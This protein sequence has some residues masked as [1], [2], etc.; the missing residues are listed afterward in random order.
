[1]KKPRL[2][3]VL[4]HCSLIALPGCEKEHSRDA[5]A[6]RAQYNT[7][8]EACLNENY[9]TALCEEFIP[10]E[11]QGDFYDISRCEVTSETPDGVN[12]EIQWTETINCGRR[13]AGFVEPSRRVTSAAAWLATVATLEAAS[14]TSFQRLAAAL[15]RLGAPHLLIARARRAIRDEVRHARIVGTLA[16]QMGAAV[17]PPRLAEVP[18]PT[19]AELAHDNAVEG[20]VGET[21]GALVATCQARS[22]APALRPLFASIAR[23]EARHAALAH[24]LAPWLAAQLTAADR[25][26]VS[27]ARRAAIARTAAED[28][29]VELSPTDRALLGIP[30]PQTL[31]AAKAAMFAMLA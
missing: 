13:P 7:L 30:A 25:A 28:V 29:G 9:C 18:P 16:Q 22:A 12:L 20:Q 14:I 23:D 10:P 31:A 27:A 5:F 15:T 24:D 26:A 2:V 1:M 21:I 3:D 11:D 19:L 8:I 17:E 4:L 6:S